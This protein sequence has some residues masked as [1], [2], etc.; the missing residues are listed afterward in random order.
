[1]FEDSLLIVAHPDDDILWL[2]SVLDKVGQIVF[3][4]ND[5]P[6]R[7]D[8]GDARKKTI[9]EYPLANVS[10]L[11]IVEARSF[12]KADWNNPVI[13]DYGIELGKNRHVDARYRAAYE[14]VVS[15]ARQLLAGRKNVYTH[16]PWGEYGHED[17][18]LVYRALKTLQAEFGYTLWFSNYC[19][20]RSVTLMNDY[21]SGFNS[22]YECLPANRSLAQDI[23]RLYE[24]HNC[25]TWFTD[26]QWFEHECLMRDGPVSREPASLSYGHNFPVNYL[27]VPLPEENT[28]AQP[29]PGLFAR[30][31]GRIRRAS[32][33]AR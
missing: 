10:T 16:N 31:A 19:S 3:C 15:A 22:D 29:A 25:W 27:K 17:H 14:D 6:H 11:D 4:F 7:E 2:S 12:N 21:I 9:A 30:I 23:A 13:T 33:R 32:G 8:I 5:M 26:Y 24:Q 18:I 20:N 1:V 28:P